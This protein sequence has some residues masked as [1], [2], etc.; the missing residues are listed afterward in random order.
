MRDFVCPSEWKTME[1]L[2]PFLDFA[3]ID[4]FDCNLLPYANGGD[5]PM[6]ISTL[7]GGEFDLRSYY[8]LSVFIKRANPS[9]RLF[10]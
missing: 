7:D 5:P 9:P 2:S 1:Q 8:Q 3:S 10:Q 4:S 6:C